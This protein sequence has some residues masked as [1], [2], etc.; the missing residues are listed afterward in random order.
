LHIFSAQLDGIEVCVT[1]AAKRTK[2]SISLNYR[3]TSHA[4]RAPRAVSAHGQRGRLSDET[5]ERV[6]SGY[7]RFK[8]ALPA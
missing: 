7:S 3:E 5:S 8:L 4:S 2:P 1:M 6:T